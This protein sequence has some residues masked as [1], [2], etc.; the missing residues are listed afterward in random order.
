MS[1]LTTL[2][3]V[4][5]RVQKMSQF[6]LDQ[7]FKVKR[8]AFDDLNTVRIEGIPYQ[9]RILAQKSISNRLTIPFEYLKRCPQ[10]I[11]AENL[12]YWIKQEKNERLFFRFKDRQVRAIFTPRYKPVDNFEV[13]ERLENLGYGPDTKVQ[14]HLDDEFMSQMGD[15]PLR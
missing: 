4:N 1:A 2:G 13:M 15:R 14:C 9:M 8:I 7:T 5:S 3:E 6:C 10:E 12:N 11:Q